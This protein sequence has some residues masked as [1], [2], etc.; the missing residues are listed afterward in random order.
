MQRWVDDQRVKAAA[1]S[2]ADMFTLARS[3]AI[4]LGRNHLVCFRTQ[5][6]PG[7]PLRSVSGGTPIANVIQDDDGLGPLPAPNGLID[8]GE[9]VVDQRAQTGL[10]WGVTFATAAAPQDADPGGTFATGLTFRKP[11]GGAGRCVLFAPDGTPR[12]FDVAPYAMGTVGSGAG[13]VYVT[14]GNRDYA[15]VL[16]PLGGIRVHAWDRAQNRWRN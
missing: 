6:D 5:Q 12:G 10:N 9:R 7:Q 2:A 13:A 8:V 4:R 16:A 1:R 15:V 11:G 14:N 3:E